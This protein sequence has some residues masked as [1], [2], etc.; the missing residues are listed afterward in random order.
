MSEADN[1]W[2]VDLDGQHYEIEVNHYTMTGRIDVLVDGSV[3][4][5]KR[6]LFT[7][8]E[9]PLR[10]GQHAAQVTVDFANLGFSA[11]SKLHVDG[12]YVEPL[13]R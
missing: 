13:R 1:T 5:R 2:R 12:R 7:Q 9:I 10:L 11:R 6:L 4:G 8:R 3:V